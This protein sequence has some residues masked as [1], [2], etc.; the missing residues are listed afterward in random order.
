MA[1]NKSGKTVKWG[2]R[3]DNERDEI[4]EPAK[5]Y[6]ISGLM[7]PEGAGFDYIFIYRGRV[8]IVEIKNPEYKGNKLPQ[9]MLTPN[10]LNAS[11]TVEWAGGDY[12]I[13]FYLNDLLAIFGIKLIEGFPISPH[14]ADRFGIKT[15]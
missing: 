9:R 7:M 15:D 10:E 11:I 5:S 13:I 12:W 1:H 3:D 4:V 6:G 8:I 14:I 2:K